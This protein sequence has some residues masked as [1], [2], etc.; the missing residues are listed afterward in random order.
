MAAARAAYENFSVD[1]VEIDLYLTK[2]GCPVVMHDS[3]I[4]RTTN[5]SGSVEAMTLEELRRYKVDGG[6]PG[7]TVLDEIPTLEDFFKEFADDDLYFLLEIKSPRFAC[8]D[9]A[10]KVIAEY[11][12]ESRVNFISFSAEQLNYARS[13]KPEISVSLLRGLN[14]L[15]DEEG[16]SRPQKV[17]D[18]VNPMNASVSADYMTVYAA[19]E[20]R[21]LNRH[22]VKVNVW[23]VNDPGRF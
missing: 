3:T 21:E 18:I 19:D 10:L 11:G 13:K 5:G 14:D 20:V 9:E 12:M 15:T 2:D 22:G 8:V 23:T 17:M 1:Y 4:D 7:T 6:Q 16:S